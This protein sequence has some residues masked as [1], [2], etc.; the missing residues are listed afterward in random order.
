MRGSLPARSR[1]RPGGLSRL[2]CTGAIVVACFAF[3][4]SD[5]RAQGTTL[6][7]SLLRAHAYPLDVTPEGLSGPGADFLRE[8]AD[9]LQFVSIGES[10]NISEIPLFT[11]ALLRDLRKRAGFR[12]IAFENGPVIM[13]MVAD[14]ARQGGVEGAFELAGRYPHAMQ[15]WTD[16]E[17]ELAAEAVALSAA[18]PVVGPGGRGPRAPRA[19]WGLDQAFGGLHI[20]ERLG[21]IA[22]SPEARTT[23]AR[24]VAEVRAIESSR[25]GWGA[26]ERWIGTENAAAAIAS[27]REISDAPAG[28]DPHRLVETLALSNRIYRMR[29][30]TG[31][32]RSNDLRERT[33]KRTFMERYREAVAAGDP[34][35]RAIAKFGHWHAGRGTSPGGVYS[36]G[37][38]L[39]ELATANGLESFHISVALLGDV[40]TLEDYPEYDP[41]PR[42][43]LDA[44]GPEGW[45]IVDLRPLRAHVATG[46]LPGIS[47]ELREL[48]LR[49]DAELLVGGAR[50]A[51]RARLL[52]MR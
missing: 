32:F 49:F 50:R 48:A 7:D 14:A 31:T 13:E 47:D 3:L 45:T 42:I 6:L 25:A 23:T 43:G 2:A 1:L 22:P 40:W 44:G 5:T 9:R 41:L 33:M 34:L 12:Y 4:A 8:M 51:T 39:S 18:D 46:A 30:G 19:V 10:H 27:L 16:E 21:R 17:V 36:L 37:N 35:P 24:I 29:G 20:L 11:R 15:F 52:G 28:S 26:S 38:F